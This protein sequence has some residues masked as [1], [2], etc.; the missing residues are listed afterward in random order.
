MTAPTE[1]KERFLR[2]A[3]T[4]NF[5]FSAASGLALLVAPG[6]IAD[7]LGEAVPQW[8]MLVLG[9]GLLLFSAGLLR[10]ILRRP[11]KRGEAIL[12]ILMD[13]V[14]V[15]AS[16]LLLALA[17][18]WFS[19]AGLWLIGAVAFAVA[20]LAVAQWLGLRRLDVDALPGSLRA[21]PR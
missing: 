21:P 17:P 4:E 20:A 14:W 5:L 8:L 1:T 9:A 10:Q 15:I 3:L 19:A 11:L 2:L 6:V 13:D 7:F 12:T 16:I 18:H